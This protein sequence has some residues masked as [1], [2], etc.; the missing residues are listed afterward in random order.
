LIFE[1]LF[2]SKLVSILVFTL[3]FHYLLISGQI[4]KIFKLKGGNPTNHVFCV[5]IY[6]RQ[7]NWDRINECSTLPFRTSL[8]QAILPVLP[9]TVNATSAGAL[10]CL[11]SV[12]V[13]YAA[14]EDIKKTTD[15]CQELL[16]EVSTKMDSLML[17]SHT[18]IQAR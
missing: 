1:E 7:S 8:L 6:F 16:T 18:A 5:F 10:H 11:F 12:L 3:F 13:G 15:V 9:N 4:I 2:S 14:L 17:H